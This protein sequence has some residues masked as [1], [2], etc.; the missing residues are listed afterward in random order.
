ME[1]R[2]YSH[3]VMTGEREQ[4]GTLWAEMGCV[5][6]PELLPLLSLLLLTGEMVT[7][8]QLLSECQTEK[9]Q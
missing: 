4:A 7:S 2:K 3:G 6:P 8:G 5:W 9:R 1:I